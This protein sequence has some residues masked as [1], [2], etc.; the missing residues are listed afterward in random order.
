VVDHAVA[1]IVVE[2]VAER[3]SRDGL[4]QVRDHAHAED[5]DHE[6]Q[7]I[8]VVADPARRHLAA[9]HLRHQ[10]TGT[11]GQALG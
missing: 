2:L 8:E 5:R 1:E 3:G 7:R 4:H 6:Q 9:Q 11:L 10:R